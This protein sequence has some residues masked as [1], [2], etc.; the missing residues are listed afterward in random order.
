M[1]LSQVYLKAPK[2]LGGDPQK[3][4]EEGEKG[5]RFG[6]DNDFLR[7]RLAEAYFANNRNE[8]AR[9]QLQV[10]LTETP[11]SDYLPEHQEALS[12]AHKLLDKH[13]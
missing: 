12:E 9:K 7:L 3:A 5:L 6:A 8:D 11:N 1:V 13:P 4:V 10:I 2:M